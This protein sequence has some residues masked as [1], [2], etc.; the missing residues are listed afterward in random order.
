MVLRPV[1]GYGIEQDVPHMDLVGI[2]VKSPDRPVVLDEENDIRNRPCRN[3]HRE[4]V[5]H[6]ARISTIA[7]GLELYF[8]QNTV[9][10]EFFSTVQSK[11]GLQQYVRIANSA[12]SA[13]VQVEDREGDE[14]L[15]LRNVLVPQ[16]RESVIRRYEEIVAADVIPV[17]ER[18]S[19]SYDIL[20]EAPPDYLRGVV[21]SLPGSDSPAMQIQT[22]HLFAGTFELR[23]CLRPEIA[24]AVA[25]IVGDVTHGR[26]AVRELDVWIEARHRATSLNHIGTSKHLAQRLS[27]C[28]TNIHTKKSSGGGSRRLLPVAYLYT[29]S[30]PSGRGRTHKVALTFERETPVGLWCCPVS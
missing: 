15:R 22:H 9:T 17:V 6:L 28:N 3:R 1:S 18:R 29:F 13:K 23:V 19:V 20:R 16:L 25:V 30:H 5:T 12:T 8:A 14:G 24:D 21:Q 4:E 2:K 10:G 26:P 11:P 27:K 7:G